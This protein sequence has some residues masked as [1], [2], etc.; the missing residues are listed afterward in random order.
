VMDG[1]EATSCIRKGQAGEQFK[2]IPIIAMTANAMK[3]DRQKC[4]DAGM[5]DYLSKPFNPDVF[6]QKL[7]EWLI[8]SYSINREPSIE[9]KTDELSNKNLWDYEGLLKRVNNQSAL[10]AQLLGIY[11]KDVPQ[12]IEMLKIAIENNDSPRAKELVHLI[13]GI[14]GNLSA[15]SLEEQ[16]SIFENAIMTNSS[17]DLLAEQCLSLVNLHSETL[18]CFKDFLH[19]SASE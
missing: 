9:K 2:A 6:E 11:I 17:S 10:V 15:G 16:A 14:A 13:K 12:N 1:Y 19:N 5:N 18:V 7:A 8:E 4:L 3:E